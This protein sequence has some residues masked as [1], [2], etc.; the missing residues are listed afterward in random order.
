[1]PLAAAKADVAVPVFFERQCWPSAACGFSVDGIYLF[2]IVM[3]VN[4]MLVISE[5]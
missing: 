5:L 2:V 3:G 1:M 4:M